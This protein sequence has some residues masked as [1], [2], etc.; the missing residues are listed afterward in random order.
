MSERL[1]FVNN[2]FLFLVVIVIGLMLTGV[3]H[4]LGMILRRSRSEFSVLITDDGPP[5]HEA[6]PSFRAINEKGKEFDNSIFTLEET[7]V[8]FLSENCLPC[9]SVLQ[10]LTKL[11]DRYGDPLSLI[12]VTEKLSDEDRSLLVRFPY[13]TTIVQD[14]SNKLKNELNINRTPFAF[15]VDAVG[16]V[17]MK[18]IVNHLDQLESLVYRRGRAIPQM[19]WENL[20][21]N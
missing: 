20:N 11:S 1:L 3:L 14:G 6:F 4:S 21:E 18:G 12:V 9:Q 13:K 8:L 2:L 5:M 16:V 10:G 17:R 7:I 15:L 19:N